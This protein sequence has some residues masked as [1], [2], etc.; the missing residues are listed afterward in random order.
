MLVEDMSKYLRYTREDYTMAE[1]LFEEYKIMREY[2]VNRENIKY[3]Y[4]DPYRNSEDFKQGFI[5][6][7]KILSSILMD[8]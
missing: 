7:V 8:L 1:K 2:V 4:V 3:S 5:A 6:G